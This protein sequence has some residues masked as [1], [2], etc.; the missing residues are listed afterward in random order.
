MR[1]EIEA[2]MQAYAA[3][4]DKEI[5][6]VRDILAALAA[7]ISSRSHLLKDIGTAVMN[8]AEPISTPQ[9]SSPVHSKETDITSTVHWLRNHHG[10]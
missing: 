1:P 5:A 3:E 2:L 4:R 8:N 6:L 10:H 7:G 9:S